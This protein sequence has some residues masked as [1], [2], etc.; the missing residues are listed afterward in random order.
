M[1][2]HGIGPLEPPSFHPMAAVLIGTS[3]TQN[4]GHHELDLMLICMQPSLLCSCLRWD[5]PP[6][7]QLTASGRTFKHGM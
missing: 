4:K 6:S 5:W 7:A 1:C 2:D 3:F